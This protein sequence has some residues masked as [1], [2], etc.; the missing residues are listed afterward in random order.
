MLNKTNILGEIDKVID[1][2]KKDF[3]EE[4]DEDKVFELSV[5]RYVL[6]KHKQEK[7][8]K[9]KI[10]FEYGDDLG[11]IDYLLSENNIKTLG[12][13]GWTVL[14]RY[15]VVY[16]DRLE[17]EEFLLIPPGEE[18]PEIVNEEDLNEEND[19]EILFEKWRVVES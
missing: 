15:Q 10:H 14:S 4:T 17:C 3:L 5:L 18:L 7:T 19:Y 12:K 1:F 9:S 13:L 11:L 6:T 16:N 2:I 8:N